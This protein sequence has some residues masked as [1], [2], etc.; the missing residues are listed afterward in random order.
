MLKV[1]SLVDGIRPW[2][3][4]LVMHVTLYKYYIVELQWLEL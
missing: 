1:I 4:E 3:G 2:G